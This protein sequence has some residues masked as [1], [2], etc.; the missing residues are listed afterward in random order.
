VDGKGLSEYLMTPARRLLQ[1]RTLLEQL[2]SY[3]EET[4]VE[5][6]NLQAAYLRVKQVVETLNF[7]M[8][9]A[10]NVLQVFEIQ[11]KFCGED[12]PNLVRSY[13]RFI[14]YASLTEVADPPITRFVVL[15]NDLCVIGSESAECPV[16]SY[17]FVKALPLRYATVKA[18]PDHPPSKTSVTRMKNIFGNVINEFLVMFVYSI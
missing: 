4:H 1:Y 12:V 6:E 5:Y 3:T 9:Q 13:R 8:S 7:A 11:T 17:K 14:R 15:L 16:G 18:I 10:E 2:I